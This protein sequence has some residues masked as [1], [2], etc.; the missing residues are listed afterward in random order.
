MTFSEEVNLVK[1]FSVQVCRLGGTV[2]FVGGYVRDKIMGISSKDIDLEIHGITADDLEKLLD[3]FGKRIETGKSFGVYNLCGC[4]VDFALPRTEEATGARHRD[5]KVYKDPFIGTKKAARRRDFTINSLMENVITGEV[6]DH[7]GGLEDIKNG[8]IRHID[9]VSFAEDP[10]RIFRAAQFA[11][12]F[13]F[14]ISPQTVDLCSKMRKADQ[15]G[16]FKRVPPFQSK[17]D[18][19]RWKDG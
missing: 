5:F 1:E 17:N 19:L 3:K 9:D 14:D 2:Y 16:R 6:T 4:S 11:A 12:R 10:L 13:K 8:V 7:F 15:D 18:G